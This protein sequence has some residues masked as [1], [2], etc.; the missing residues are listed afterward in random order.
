M[1]R[2]NLESLNPSIPIKLYAY[3]GNDVVVPS[4]LKQY[5]VAKEEITIF[6]NHRMGKDYIIKN[7]EVVVIDKTN[8][9]CNPS[10][11]RISISKCV[12]NFLEKELNCSTRLLEGNQTMETCGPDLLKNYSSSGLPRMPQ[13]SET[14]MFQYFGCTPSCSRNEIELTMLNAYDRTKG[15]K[16]TLKLV[17]YFMDGGFEVKEEYY[18]YDYASFLADCGGYMGLLLGYS[19]LSLYIIISEWI[20]TVC[21]KKMTK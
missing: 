18:L 5:G 21:H 11:D 8:E 12:S 9:R 16:T 10:A 15:N 4:E 20:S 13:L 1:I 17:F 7:T 6:P 2:L 14:L 19:W 3:Y